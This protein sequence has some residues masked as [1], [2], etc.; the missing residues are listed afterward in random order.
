MG[1]PTSTARTGT[2]RSARREG[3]RRGAGRVAAAVAACTLL[4]GATGCETVVDRTTLGDI[5][6][7]LNART[8]TYPQNSATSLNSLRL[9]NGRRELAMDDGLK[10]SAEAWASTMRNRWVDAGCRVPQTQLA[11]SVLSRQYN[12]AAA[13]PGFTKGGENVGVVPGVAPAT[14]AGRAAAIA[15]LHTT[16]MQS[17]THRANILD[18]VYKEVGIAVVYG[19]TPEQQ[20]RVAACGKVATNSYLWS[21]HAFVG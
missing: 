9:A 3:R 19:P 11:H 21:T 14:Q 20:K 12:L 13:L 5:A 1:T 16:Y 6:L 8:A 18:P 10:A 7:S 15:R 2:A 4:L 17:P